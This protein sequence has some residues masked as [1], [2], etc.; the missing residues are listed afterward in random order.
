MRILCTPYTYALSHISRPLL[1]AQELKSRGHEVIFAGDSPYDSFIKDAGFE[2]LKTYQIPPEILFERIRRNSLQFVK[3]REM[4]SMIE[5]D[6]SLI[7]L[8]QPD[9]IL[10]DG[11]FSAPFSTAI[12]NIFHT[13]IVNVSSTEYRALPYVPFLDRLPSSITGN[14]LI[15]NKLNKLNL[16]LEMAIFN[17]TNPT[18]RQLTKN[19]SLSKHITATNCLTGNDLTLLADVPEY[20]PT[21]KLPEDYHYIGPLTWKSN[22]P[23]PDWWPPTK[24][25]KLIYFTMGTTWLGESL[26]SLLTKMDK[27]QLT[28]IVTTGGQNKKI[29]K[30]NLKTIPGKIYL[31]D[32]IDGDLAISAS[33]CVV[34][35]G[36]NGTI[37]QALQQGKPIIGIP[38]IPDQAFNMRRVESLGIGRMLSAHDLKN[39]PEKLFTLITEV[40]TCPDYKNKAEMFQS[41]IKKLTPAKHSADLIENLLFFR[42]EEGKTGQNHE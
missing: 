6:R 25:S 27:Q 17:A 34:C 13:A 7:K 10:S 37:Y 14:S 1:V 42:N 16:F 23:Q 30:G 12:D 40:T 33:D 36:G 39:N 3:K 8:F 22:L 4:I 11:R 24:K 35:H 29:G 41:L 32:F 9:I 31:E 5:A 2:V 15:N 20:F 38:T 28:V 26:N 19:Y 18:F 21:T